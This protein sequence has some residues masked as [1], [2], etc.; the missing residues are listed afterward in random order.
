MRWK[1][2]RQSDNIEDRRGQGAVGGGGLAIGG[3]GG[4]ILILA[5]ALLGG[6]P[7]ALMNQAPATPRMAPAQEDE[8]KEFVAV[9]LADTEEVWQEEFRRRGATYREPKLVLFTGSV[10]SGCGFAGA[11]MGPF[12]CPADST[13]YIDL[14][15]FKEMQDR[16]GIAGEFARAYVIAHE[17][18]HHVQNLLGTSDKVQSRQG[19]VSQTDMNRLTVRLELQADFYAGLW[20]NKARNMAS[21]DENDIRSAINAAHAIGDDTLQKKSQ[22]RVVP[23]AFTHGTSEQRMKWFMRGFQSGRMEDGDTFNMPYD[24][25]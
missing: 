11:Q 24:Q 22:G 4:L 16:F 13:V 12:Y 25:L 9:T 2:R 15:F 18:G 19:R 3:I 20:A 7:S 6:D 14:G 23:D 10:R 1:G 5:I 8:L 21:L 17:V